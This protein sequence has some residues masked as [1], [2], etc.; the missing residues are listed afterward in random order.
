MAKVRSR[1]VAYRATSARSRLPPPPP[2]GEG[3]RAKLF[4]NGRSQAVR[5]PKEF[6]LPGNEV[7]IRR[8]GER[9]ILEPIGDEPV[10]ANGWPIGFWD[11]IRRRAKGIDFPDVEP[12]GA[13]FLEPE[14]FEQ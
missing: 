4:A 14:E 6:R 1:A 10:D 13:H 12:M 11:D 9:I 3:Q 8:D 7:L 2:A 5:L